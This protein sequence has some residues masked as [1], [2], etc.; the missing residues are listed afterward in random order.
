MARAYAR[1]AAIVFLITG[2][3]GLLTGDASHV[4]HGRAGGNFDGVALHLTYGRDV[5]DLGLAALFAYAGWFR[6]EQDAW[7]PVLIA[8]ALLMLLAV[9][10]FVH[11]D[12]EAGTRAIASLHFPLAINVLDLIAGVLAVLCG[13]GGIAE[14]GPVPAVRP[15]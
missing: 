9:V 1:L 4:V 13:L 15:R 3:G 6:R 11:A 5:L 7:L 8:A 12:D 14:A 10:G 2:L